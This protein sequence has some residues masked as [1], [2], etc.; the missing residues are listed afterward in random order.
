LTVALNW[1]YNKIRGIKM[2]NVFWKVVSFT[3]NG[4]IESSTPMEHTQAIR[5]LGEMQTKNPKGT[6][7]WLSPC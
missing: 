5:V 1:L 7:C 6:N 2:N 3:P 4:V